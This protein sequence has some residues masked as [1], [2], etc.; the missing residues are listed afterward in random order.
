M[1]LGCGVVWLVA[2][3]STTQPVTGVGGVGVI[4]LKQSARDC[5]SHSMNHG[6]EGDDCC[7]GGRVARGGMN[8][9]PP[10]AP[11]SRTGVSRRR[12]VALTS[13]ELHP[14]MG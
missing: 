11:E 2:S 12:R 13:M 14:C 5:G 1:L 10:A 8:E 4:E 7:G 6:V 9:G 3:E